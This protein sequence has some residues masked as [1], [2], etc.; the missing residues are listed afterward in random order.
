MKLPA[1]WLPL[2][3]ATAATAQ[4]V[5]LPI[6]KLKLPPE[7][8]QITRR[9]ALTLA[10]LNNITGGGYYSELSVG[11]PPQRMQVMLDTGSSDTWVVS[12]DAQLCTSR[13]MQAMY[14]GCT[15]TCKYFVLYALGF[16][17]WFS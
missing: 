13:R 2:A 16:S 5:E 3:A 8:I 1:A 17:L 6:Q 9:D 4:T 10:S 12:G 15:V 14:G 7:L 11:T